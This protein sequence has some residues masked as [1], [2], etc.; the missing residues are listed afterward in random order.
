MCGAASIRNGSRSVKGKHP[1]AS[2]RPQQDAQGV[3]ITAA[4]TQRIGRRRCDVAPLERALGHPQPVALLAL[5]DVLEQIVHVLACRAKQSG[6][7]MSAMRSSGACLGRTHV[8]SPTPHH[9]GL[10]SRCRPLHRAARGSSAACSACWGKESEAGSLGPG[11]MKT[12]MAL[13]SSA[14]S[15]SSAVVEMTFALPCATARRQQEW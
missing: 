11:R 5:L 1:G 9:A 2:R 8:Q 3:P 7:Q 4:L 14:R 12:S 6:S 10:V 15:A 13:A